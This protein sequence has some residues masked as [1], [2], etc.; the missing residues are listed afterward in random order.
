MK[1]K[2]LF[3]G[4]IC[5][6]TA[7]SGPST[8]M[9]AIS[10]EA[11][12]E[13]PPEAVEPVELE[14]E[15]MDNSA[16]PKA[17]F[18]QFCNGSWIIANPVPD[19]KSRYS[20]FSEVSDKIDKRLKLILL[21]MSQ[22]AHI[23]GSNEQI[24]ADFYASYM[25]TIHRDDIGTRHL[26]ETMTLE[27]ANSIEDAVGIGNVL[28]FHHPRG[29]GS[30][31]NFYVEI[32]EKDNSQYVAYMAQGG[33][34]LPNRGYYLNKD[35]RS[36]T[37]RTK[38]KEHIS[39]VFALSG[40]EISK[41][42]VD[43]IFN[44]EKELATNSRTQEANRDNNAKYNPHTAEEIASKYPNIDWIK[45][46]DKIGL[47]K[48]DKIIVQQPEFFAHVD[49]MM[50]SVPIKSWSLYLSWKVLNKFE[51]MMTSELNAENFDFYSRTMRGKK[52]M[53]K[54]WK[55]AIQRITRSPINEILGKRFVD[56]KFSQADKIKV[57]EMVDN[58]TTVFEERIGGLEW[59]SDET[60][61][62]A[63]EKLHAF[64]RK[65]GFPDKWKTY[66]GLQISDS[67][68]LENSINLSQ[69]RFN[70]KLKKLN[71]SI[72][73]SLWEMPAHMVNAYYN[74]A[75]NEIVFPAGIMQN[76]FFDP[77]YED[78]VN[79][80]RMGAVIGHELTHGFDD[81]GAKYAADG[82]LQNWWTF[83]DSVKFAEKTE[84]LISQY[85]QFEVLDGV[86]I[87][88]KLTLGEN[89]ADFGGLTIAYY[90]YLKSLEGK[91]RTEINGYTNEQRFF[92]AFGQ[93]WKN[94]IK[95]DELITRVNTDY[96]SPGKYRVNGTLGNMPEFFEAFDVKEGDPMR[97]S[98]DKIAKIW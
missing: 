1:S 14:F 66:E 45:Y 90:A 6:L 56:V 60:K 97:Q 34:G 79:Y 40:S 75:L 39:K 5:A 70:D 17:D 10:S 27:F 57:N 3:I 44:L 71:N 93:V 31:F 49:K 73:K 96:H 7:C 67:N 95:D 84:K 81:Q 78:A 38:Y 92:I 13:N 85:N 8:D 12:N 20:S 64:A 69:Y 15:Y 76:P 87:K 29:I 51:T 35:E 86:F 58:I 41:S 89:I 37:L 50:N 4:A 83:E 24:L 19:D 91:E 16:D 42:D 62:K 11:G 55:R 32:D 80:A 43:A 36:T 30:L 53:Q 63:K 33:L 82:N 47:S 26:D 77:G 28:A 94:T 25:D 88:G 9:E 72:D 74:P 68:Y 52:V 98:A 2:I 22:E 21:D 54:D 48:T 59:M 61:V 18:Y 65:L 23:D 46:F